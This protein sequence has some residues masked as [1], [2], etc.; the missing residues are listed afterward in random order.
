MANVYTQ[1]FK[2]HGFLKYMVITICY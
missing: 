2:R 1:Y